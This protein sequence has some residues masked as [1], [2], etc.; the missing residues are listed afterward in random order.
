[1]AFEGEWMRG[2]HAAA[3]LDMMQIRDTTARSLEEYVSMASALGRD[4]VRRNEM[5]ARIAAN[6]HRVYRDGDCIAGLSAFFEAAVRK[7]SN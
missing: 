5:S 7:S 1:V 4:T 3:I 2:R 6:K